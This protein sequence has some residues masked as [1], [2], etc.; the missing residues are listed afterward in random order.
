LLS[1]EKILMQKSNLNHCSHG[2]VGSDDR[3]RRDW[4]AGE[5]RLQVRL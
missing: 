1:T 3:K 5:A 2:S 4:R